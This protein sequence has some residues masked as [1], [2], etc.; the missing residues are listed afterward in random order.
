MEGNLIYHYNQLKMSILS[1]LY[2]IAVYHSNS[3]D[4]TTNL[5]IGWFRTLD[6]TYIYIPGLSRTYVHGHMSRRTDRHNWPWTFQQKSGHLLNE[7]RKKLLFK[8]GIIS[9]V[10]KKIPSFFEIS[11]KIVSGY[12]KLENF[13]KILVPKPGNK[14]SKWKVWPAAGGISDS[15]LSKVA[16]SLRPSTKFH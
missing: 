5:Q 15:G 16:K 12:Q 9:I 6:L 4:W 14:S 8:N 7:F 13:L 10:L 2:F 3:A 11:R 1:W